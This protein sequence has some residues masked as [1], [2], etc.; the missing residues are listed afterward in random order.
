MGHITVREEMLNED[1]VLVK[2]FISQLPSTVGRRFLQLRLENHPVKEIGRQYNVTEK[3][4]KEIFR[5][6]QRQIEYLQD[7]KDGK[8]HQRK[9][10]SI[11]EWSVW[12]AKH[13]PG[14]IL[15]EIPLVRPMID[16]CFNEH[17]E[18]CRHTGELFVGV[19]VG[20]TNVKMLSHLQENYFK[21]L[22]GKPPDGKPFEE[23]F[24][25]R[26]ELQRTVNR[27][28]D[29]R[30]GLSGSRIITATDGSAYQFICARCSSDNGKRVTTMMIRE[31]Q[32]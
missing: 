12:V 18:E 9:F 22:R 1:W 32:S 27:A 7:V 31:V 10:D 6:Q 19:L 8:R 11:L 20:D 30:A 25:E 14:E 13:S 4:A 5:S 29:S 26:N 2:D 16:R 24:I 17:A 3:V 28:W 15:R 21:E 23:Y